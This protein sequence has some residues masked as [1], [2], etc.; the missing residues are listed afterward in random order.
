[1]AAGCDYSVVQK[2]VN[3]LLES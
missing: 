1:M 3:R 2:G